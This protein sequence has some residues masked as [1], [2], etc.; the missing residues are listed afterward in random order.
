[1]APHTTSSSQN[2]LVDQKRALRRLMA[3]RRD[4]LPVEEQAR[5]SA[6][7]AARLV[8][9]PEI[10]ARL[11]PGRTV[12]GYVAAQGE[13]DPGPALA[14]C[15]MRGAEVVLPRVVDE[16][17]RLRFHRAEGD[18]AGLAVGRFGLL[19]PPASAREVALEAID[20]VIVPGLAFDSAGRRLGR[21]GGYYD[22]AAARLRAAGRGLLVGLGYDFQ[23][24]DRCPAGEGDVAVDCVV[25]DQ[26]VVRCDSPRES[27]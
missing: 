26:R 6:A 5:L 17:P 2:L 18:A 13:I 3:E 15:R 11:A 7:A 9:V 19:E 8:A 23:L 25:T 4:G 24:V 12:S 1:M 10:A 14:E 27:A 21:G 22:E 16:E 20:V